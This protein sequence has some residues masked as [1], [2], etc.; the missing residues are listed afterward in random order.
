M[1]QIEFFFFKQ[2]TAYEIPNVK[3][4]TYTVLTNN[5]PGGAFRGFGGPQGEYLAEMQMAKLAEKLG[6]DPVELRL[7]NVLREG[8]IL[9]VGTPIP[10]GVS[11]AQVTE[12]CAIEA[13]WIK[14]TNNHWRRPARASSIDPAKRYGLGF[15]IGYKNVGFSFGAVEKSVVRMELRGGAEIEEAIVYHAAAEVGQGTHTVMAQM[16][17]E[18]AGVPYERVTLFVSDTATMGNP[19]SASASRMTFMAGNAIKGAVAAA[20]EKWKNEERPAIAEYT[21]LAPK[22]QPFDPETGKSVP[23]FSYAYVAQAVAAGTFTVMPAL[24]QEMYS[25]DVYGKSRAEKLTVTE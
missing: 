5:I 25:P 24:A 14:D 4:D 9:S 18:A 19:G 20:L 22:T 15:A 16:A 1:E 8:S 10:K 21:Y 12:K 17:A 13:G 7:K 6:I 11:I 23:N 2:K 3:V